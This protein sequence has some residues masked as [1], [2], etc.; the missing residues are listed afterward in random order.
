M[1]VFGKDKLDPEKL[2][3]L[4]FAVDGINYITLRKIKYKDITIPKGYIFDGV[5]IKAPFTMLFS[6]KDLKQGIYASCVHDWICQHKE[7]YYRKDATDILVKIWQECGLEPV[8]A[9]IVKISVNIFQFFKGGWK[10]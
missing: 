7:D 6:N 2:N 10:K 8:K 4:Y 3:K 9:F 1:K 5:T